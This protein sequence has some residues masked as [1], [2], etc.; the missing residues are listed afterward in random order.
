MRRTLII[1]GALLLLPLASQ[2]ATTRS[3][4]SGQ[5][6]KVVVPVKKTVAKKIVTKKPLRKTSSL[7]GRGLSRARQ[8][9]VVLP[10]DLTGVIVMQKENDRMWYVTPDTKKRYFLKD[11]GEA[12][13]VIEA[14]KV[15]VTPASLM[16]IP[17]NAPAKKTAANAT[18]KL[19][20]GK[21]IATAENEGT[22]WYIDP[23]T[24]IRVTL[25]EPPDAWFA[26][27]KQIAAVATEKDIVQYAMNREQSLSMFDPL[28]SGVAY[29]AYDGLNFAG[30]SND[31]R[32]LPLAS[33]SKLMTALV[34][35]DTNPD[36]SQNFTI[37][38]EVI[39]YPKTLIP[40]DKT[41]EVGY[42]VGDTVTLE[43]MRVALL[44]ASSNQSADAL[45]TA[46]GLPREEFLRRM[47]E[48]A[49]LFGLTHTAFYDVAGLDVRNVSTPR[50]MAVIAERAFAN[51]LIASTSV[52]TAY[53]I[54]AT[55]SDGQLRPIVVTNR[56]TSLL[57]FG[58]EGAKSGYLVEAQRNAV[59]R[60]DGK[61]LIVMHARSLGERNSIIG[62]L[63]ATTNLF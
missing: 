45:A 62:K 14:L 3:T 59:I 61:I 46:T 55:Q 2:A 36:W 63:L 43:D 49:Q 28:F 5:A 23:A 29:V 41:S 58:V 17:T 19:Y 51:D 27:L 56:N 7:E 33:L 32:V 38:P 60:K 1:I 44:V 13:S 26:A 15:I 25:G 6:K 20:L 22:V 54:I 16:K 47:N 30:G 21:F 31:Q 48:K 18:T 4:S 39:N 52:T 9:K 34:V 42:R 53:T 50:E 11:S 10:K 8:A 24:G 12:Q 37:T 40:D 57:A 35:M